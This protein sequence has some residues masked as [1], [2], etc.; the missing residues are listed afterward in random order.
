M[1]LYVCGLKIPA[2][3]IVVSHLARLVMDSN[4][5]CCN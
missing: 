3:R 4:M 5:T 2:V 1:D